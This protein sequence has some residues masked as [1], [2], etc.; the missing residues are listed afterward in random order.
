MVSGT[1]L[2]VLSIIEAR[3]GPMIAAA[4]GRIFTQRTTITYTEEQS[5][6][7]VENYLQAME[8]RADDLERSMRD[9][10]PTT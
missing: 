4:I 5:Q 8:L 9:V 1:L 6:S 2:K 10:P 3:F 7:F